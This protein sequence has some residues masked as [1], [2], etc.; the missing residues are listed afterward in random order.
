MPGRRRRCRRDARGAVRP[1]ATKGDR[2]PRRFDHAPRPIQPGRSVPSCPPSGGAHELARYPTSPPRRA[3]RAIPSPKDQYTAVYEACQPQPES[4]SRTRGP[5]RPQRRHSACRSRRGGG[6]PRSTRRGRS[7]LPSPRPRRRTAV[8][9]KPNDLHGQLRSP[10]PH[11]DHRCHAVVEGDR[12]PSRGEQ[13]TSRDL[14]SP[15][16]RR[17]HPFLCGR[18]SRRRSSA[19][20][21]P[22]ERGAGAAAGS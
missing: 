7:F 22:R 8:F 4:T 17:A 9:P 19:K 2:L 1:P 15:R 18:T 6:S 5:S 14:G 21:G 12:Q 16:L 3:T 13:Y 20:Y 11:R 10:L